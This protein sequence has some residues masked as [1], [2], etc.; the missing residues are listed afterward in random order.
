MSLMTFSAPRARQ[1]R[2]HPRRYV[3]TNYL[4]LHKILKK[5]DKNIPNAACRQFYLTQLHREPWLA[6]G[7]G[8]VL[9]KLSAIFSQLRG[10]TSGVKNEDAAQGFVRT[11]TK[12][13]VRAGDIST[14]KYRVLQHL[15]VFQFDASHS[16]GDAQLINSVYLDNSSAELYHGR[17]DKRPDA[18][19][20]RLRW[21][22]RRASR[23]PAPVRQAGR[24][25]LWRL[26]TVANICFALARAVLLG[27]AR[28]GL[29]AARGQQTQVSQSGQSNRIAWLKRC[30][31]GMHKRLGKPHRRAVGCI[32]A[33]R[34]TCAWHSSWCRYGTGPP[35]TVFVERKTHR[36]GWKG[37]TSVKERFTLAEA[38]VLPFLHGTFTV[39]EVRIARS[40][41]R[42]C[43]AS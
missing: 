22:A 30:T 15:P 40:S 13:W 28:C 4:G 18:I 6:G 17:L 24:A 20:L 1:T 26:E 8:D 43:G 19:A 11:T 37:E 41:V 7:Y 39:D 31:Q 32:L 16:A 23:R 29:A 34:E 38:R 33:G 36:E 35:Q 14:V 21:C 42:L 25:N 27:D 2:A 5:H 3:N 12:Y 9:T 10:D